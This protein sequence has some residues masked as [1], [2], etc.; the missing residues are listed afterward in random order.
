V[1]TEVALKV[2][3]PRSATRASTTINSVRVNARQPVSDGRRRQDGAATSVRLAGKEVF[4]G[5]EILELGKCEPFLIARPGERSRSHVV[6][7]PAS[8][9]KTLVGHGDGGTERGMGWPLP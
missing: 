7:G 1:L 8:F 2:R 4:I 9:V 6:V 5:L 3:H